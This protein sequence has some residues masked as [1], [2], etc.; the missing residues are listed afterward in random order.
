MHN[1]PHNAWGSFACREAPNQ[2]SLTKKQNYNCSV[3]C[4]LKTIRLA[5]LGCQ[6]SGQNTAKAERVVKK[7][8]LVDL[9]QIHRLT[10]MNCPEFH[11]SGKM[12]SLVDSAGIGGFIFFPRLSVSCSIVTFTV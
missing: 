5:G 8:V 11:F 6:F 3:L 4:G 7:H 2:K 12:F 1:G 9:I 10:F